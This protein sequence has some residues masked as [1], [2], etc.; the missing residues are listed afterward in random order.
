M[1]HSQE[2]L[3]TL[4]KRYG[5]NQK[6][7]AKWRKRSSVAD[8]PTGPKEP[9][10]A[11]RSVGE[12]AVIVAFRRYALLPLDECLYALQQIIADAV[13]LYFRSAEHRV[14]RGNVVGARHCCVSRNDTTMGSQ[15][16]G[17]LT[18]SSRKKPPRKCLASG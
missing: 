5:V 8:L 12:E 10:S 1:Q 16:L 3:R 17:P 11:V 2:S 4:S 18:P 13:G 14:R 15:V 7:V 6:T 9:R